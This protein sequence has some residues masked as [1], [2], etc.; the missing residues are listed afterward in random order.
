MVELG[1]N[2]VL[3]VTEGE[4]DGSE[5]TEGSVRRVWG[6]EA[7]GDDASNGLRTYGECGKHWCAY[8]AQR[9]PRIAGKWRAWRERRLCERSGR[10]VGQRLYFDCEKHWSWVR[11]RRG[12]GRR[13][14]EKEGEGE[15]RERWL[16]FLNTRRGLPDTLVCICM[17]GLGRKG[18]SQ[19]WMHGE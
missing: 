2:D 11:G 10:V 13:E 3:E 19:N 15:G 17:R 5:D 1:R 9:K 12:R 18:R 16:V 7:A 8:V 6:C 4:M 14:K